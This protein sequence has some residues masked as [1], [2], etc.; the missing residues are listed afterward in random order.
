MNLLRI[1][2]MRLLAAHRIV[3]C[4]TLSQTR[5]ALLA[6]RLP[7]LSASPQSNGGDTQNRCETFPLQ[8][9][10]NMD[11]TLLSECNPVSPHQ[12]TTE[13]AETPLSKSNPLFPLQRPPN[14]NVQRYE[15]HDN[16]TREQSANLG[17]ASPSLNFIGLPHHL[18]QLTPSSGAF[19]RGAIFANA[20][21]REPSE[22]P[23]G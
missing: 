6:L 8:R 20:K 15:R 18:F 17:D 16:L 22:S 12:R 19:R 2:W 10:P 21:N 11:A 9:L 4:I 14:F 3:K 23:A 1:H 5:C 7:P 13:I